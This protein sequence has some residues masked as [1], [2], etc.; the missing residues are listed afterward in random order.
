MAS[1][2]RGFSVRNL[3]S[4]CM[5]ESEWQTRQQRIDTRLRALCPPWQI[6]RESEGFDRSVTPADPRPH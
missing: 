3:G 6:I 4:S 1:Q 2:A 5:T